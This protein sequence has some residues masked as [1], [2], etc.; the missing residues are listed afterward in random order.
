MNVKKW[1]DKLEDDDG[2][3]TGRVVG[4][5]T[6]GTQ[7]NI[8]DGRGLWGTWEHIGNNRGT[9]WEQNG[10]IIQELPMSWRS[11]CTRNWNNNERF[12]NFWNFF[13]LVNHDVLLQFTICIIGFL[14]YVVAKNAQNSVV[15]CQILECSH[16]A[17]FSWMCSMSW[18]DLK[19][20]GHIHNMILIKEKN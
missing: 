20:G 18:I 8:M 1:G 5:W 10:P 6:K 3:L 17:R 13:R 4:C 11:H 12:L 15:Y 9:S 7:W 16:I 2:E 14:N 19:I